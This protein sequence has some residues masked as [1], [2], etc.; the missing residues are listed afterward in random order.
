MPDVKLEL[1]ERTRWF[2]LDT[3]AAPGL[4]L[5]VHPEADPPLQEAVEVGPSLYHQAAGEIRTR[6]GR[7]RQDV[8]SGRS[9]IPEPDVLFSPVLTNE[10][11]IGSDMLRAFVL[12]FDGVRHRLQQHPRTGTSAVR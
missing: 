11:M 7:L 5:P 12:T 1:G 10:G 6:R 2:N 8:P 3:G 4:I 9:V